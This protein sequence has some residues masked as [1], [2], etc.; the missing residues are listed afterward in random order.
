ME[1][2]QSAPT[3]KT[4]ICMEMISRVRYLMAPLT[5]EGSAKVQFKECKQCH[6]WGSGLGTRL[7]GVVYWQHLV[8]RSHWWGP[9]V[10]CVWTRSHWGPVLWTG[11]E[12]CCL[13]EP[14]SNLRLLNT[15]RPSIWLTYVVT[16]TWSQTGILNNW[17]M[18]N[19]TSL[20]IS[21]VALIIVQ[22]R[23]VN[24]GVTGQLKCKY[25]C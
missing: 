21:C 9:W 4:V 14:D 7:K 17:K 13:Y 19:Y 25:T 3:K 6:A 15:V 18:N 1:T 22:V 16:K 12:G 23:S 10:W 5:S 24:L 20:F 2:I 8:P 11:M